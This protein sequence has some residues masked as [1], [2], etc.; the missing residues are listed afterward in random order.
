MPFHV[1]SGSYFA[2]NYSPDGDTIR[3]KPDDKADLD[4]LEG[5]PVIPNARGHVSLRLEGIDALETHF[6][7]RHQPLTFANLARDQLLDL[8]GIAD[9]KWDSNK[10][11]VVSSSD[12]APGFIVARATDKFRRVI[13]FL[14]KGTLPA[15]FVTGGEIFLDVPLLDKSVNAQMIRDGLAYPTFYSSLF[16]GLRNHIS[17]L[18]TASRA[19]SKGLYA[20]DTTNRLFTV[21]HIG[22]LTEQHVI[23]P[24]LFRRA[25]AYVAGAGSIVG[26]KAMLELNQEPVFDLVD[27]NFTHFDTFIE[28]SGNQVRLTRMPEHLVFDPMPE[29]PGGEF[30]ALVNGEV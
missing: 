19:A 4:L 9:V 11:S 18:A 14:F 26:F 25:S 8:V 6:E 20:F 24:K 5:V 7:G 23:M 13:A 3:F 27:N 15:G 17:A 28:E 12:G 22:A 29:R 10:G 16:A 2:T 30:T 21:D 1:I